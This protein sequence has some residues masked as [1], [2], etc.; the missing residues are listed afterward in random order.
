MNKFTDG[1][2]EYKKGD[3]YF[4]LTKI[5]ARRNKVNQEH[6]KALRLE[7]AERIKH[8]HKLNIQM[9]ILNR[10]KQELKGGTQWNRQRF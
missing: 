5:R 6:F 10:L 1:L 2:T 9:G 4:Y 3:S 7:R 8:T